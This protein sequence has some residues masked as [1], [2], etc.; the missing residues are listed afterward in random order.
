[1]VDD[2]LFVTSLADRLAGLTGVEAVSLG[3]SRASGRHRPDSDWDLGL[4]YR[5]VLDPDEIR[6]LG[7]PGEVSEIGGWGGGVMNGGAW[8]SVEGRNVDLHYR[9][10]ADVERCIDEAEDGHFHKELLAFHLAGVP[11]YLPAAELGSGR[12][13]VGHLPRPAMPPT[14]RVTGRIRWHDDAQLSLGY[15]R[16]ALTGEGDLVVAAGNVA[17]GVIEEAHSRCCAR[18]EWVTNEKGLVE[19]AGLGVVAAALARRS[20]DGIHD[21]VDRLADELVH[22]LV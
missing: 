3:G 17:R 5:G 7:Y 14:L 16:A 2:E 11:S 18:G 10:L 21:A 20:A 8:L 15:A 9:D 6:R 19:R 1:M 22:A 4:Y 13:L 12:T